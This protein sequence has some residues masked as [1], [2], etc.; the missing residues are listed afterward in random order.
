MAAENYREPAGF[1]FL[2]AV[3]IMFVGIAC[4]PLVLRMIQFFSA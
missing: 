4:L 1:K 3:V 2:F